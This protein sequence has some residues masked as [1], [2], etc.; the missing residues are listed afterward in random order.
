[1]TVAEVFSLL[2]AKA[3][4]KVL[5]LE[6]RLG[7]EGKQFGVKLGDLRAIAKQIGSDQVLAKELWD[8]GNVDAQ[9]VAVLILK[10][11][12]ISADAME[13]MV[14]NCICLQMI[15]WVS[16]YL[17]KLNPHKEALRQKWMHESH[18]MLARAAWSLTAS[19]VAKD[20]TG[21]DLGALLDRI[22]V[23]MPSAESQPKWT[24]NMCLAEI[25]INHP[26]L[27]PRALEIGERLGVYRD[28]PVS[29]GCVSPFAPIWI[30]E[31]SA[32]KG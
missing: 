16:S 11:G 9:L 15:D 8:S 19:R 26:E 1:M 6:Y 5:K 23:E 12:S 31:M 2:E 28:Y 24:M 32:R 14:R 3:D 17:L 30:N 18:P 25:G 4:S 13:Q 22:E 29:K 21:L 7:A 27:R 10:P 20:P